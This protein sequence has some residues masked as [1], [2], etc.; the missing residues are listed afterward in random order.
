MAIDCELIASI[1]TVNESGGT[2]AD[3]V[4]LPPRKV[5]RLAAAG[6]IDIA[7]DAEVFIFR[8]LS[9]SQT[10]FI[11]LN[12][13]ADATA[14]TTGDDQ[15]IRVEAGESFSFGLAANVDAAGYKLMVA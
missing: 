11:R 10:V 12:A 13:D 8:N 6:S 7:S 9:T 1:G 3:A 15:S 5:T 2:R 14:A 4:Q